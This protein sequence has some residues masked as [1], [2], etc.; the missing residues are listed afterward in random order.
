M[1][2]ASAGLLACS[3]PAR[4]PIPVFRK[5]GFCAGPAAHSSGAAAVLHRLPY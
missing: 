1:V 2:C 5:S 3:I 4:L